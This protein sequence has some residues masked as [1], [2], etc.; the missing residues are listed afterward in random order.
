MILVDF[1]VRSQCSP[2]SANARETDRSGDIAALR[3]FEGVPLFELGQGAFMFGA[4]ADDLDDDED[5][6]G[7]E[8]DAD[9]DNDADAQVEGCVG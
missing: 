7:E 4:F 1:F 5:A 6:C 2:A 3:G 8:E 9:A